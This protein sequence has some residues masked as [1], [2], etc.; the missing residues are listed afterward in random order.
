[1]TAMARLN[2]ST[3]LAAGAGLA[4]ALVLTACGGDNGGAAPNGSDGDSGSSFETLSVM[5][6]LLSSTAP[7]SDGELQT[8]IEEH[9][10]TGLDMTWVPNS[11]Y[12]ERF[13]VMMASDDIPHVVVVQGK[14]GAFTQAAEAGAYWDLTDYLE[15]YEN[16]TPESD[17]IRLA[18][19]VNGQSYGVLRLRDPMRA[20]VILRRDWLDNLGLDEPESVDDLYEIARAFT[21]DDPNES[22][23]DDTYGLII[24]QWNGFANGGPYDLI[25]VWHG[26][27]NAWGE[28]DDG[29]LYPAFEDE[30]F[31]ESVNFTKDMIDNG[32]VNSDFATMD[33]ATWNEPFFNGEGGI[34]IDVSSRAGQLLN[35]FKEEHPEDYTDYVTM[36]GNLDGPDGDLR[37]YPTSGYFGFLA[38]PTATVQTEEELHEVLSILNDL[39][40]QEGQVLLNHGIEGRN[41]EV[42]EDRARPIADGGAEVETISNDVDAF[43]QIGTQS[44]GWLG[45]DPYFD[46]EIEQEID[47]ERWDIHDADFEQAIFNPAAPLISE[48]YTTQGAVLD[49]IVG[50][51]RIRYLAGQLDEE[52]F[53]AEVQRWYDQGGEQIVEE[54]NDLYTE[55]EN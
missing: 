13:N 25:E 27:P 2:P 36:V 34:I 26:A 24:P 33:S 38:I 45:Y 17:E 46:N 1:M 6:P 35:L 51:A 16:L 49:Q 52:G 40:A 43:A 37:A 12:D 47:E 4:M 21:E 11:S 32:Y 3:R 48:T 39:S 30:A 8:A 50:D 14:T 23:S 29:R 53:R 20:A 42:V 19:S 28:D 7:S 10:G 41:F 22:G 54:M 31:F 44:N 5:A 15:Q 18:A 9:I 55:L